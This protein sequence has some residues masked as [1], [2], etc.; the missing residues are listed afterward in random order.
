MYNQIYTSNHTECEDSISKRSWMQP[1]V[2][3]KTG[4]KSNTEIADDYKN[5]IY[6][7]LN[8]TVRNNTTS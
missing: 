4:R 8:F 2:M 1:Q 7:L 5:L 3:T 6:L